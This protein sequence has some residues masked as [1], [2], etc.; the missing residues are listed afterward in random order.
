MS[1]PRYAL[2]LWLLLGLFCLRVLGQMLVA[3]AGVTFLPPMKEWQSGLLPYP[4]LLLSQF[5]IIGLFAKVAA[6]FTQ[7]KGIL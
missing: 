6:D 4:V 1:A 2:W 7:Q 5:A 3:F